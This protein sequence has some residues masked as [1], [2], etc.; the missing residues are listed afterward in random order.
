MFG[1]ETGGIM[2]SPRPSDNGAEIL[3]AMPMRPFYGVDVTLVDDKVLVIVD[4]I[5][6]ENIYR[7]LPVLKLDERTCGKLRNDH[8]LDRTYRSD[9]ADFLTFYLT[10][11]ISILSNLI[12]TKFRTLLVDAV[13]R[14]ACRV[15]VSIKFNCCICYFL[16]Q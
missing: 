7:N 13:Q 16:K 14:R 12:C 5:F 4:S 11:F 8:R 3:P 6:T 10:N 15:S 2:I 1:T 9:I